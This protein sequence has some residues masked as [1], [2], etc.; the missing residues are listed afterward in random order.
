LDL[1]LYKNDGTGGDQIF[2]KNSTQNKPEHVL[3]DRP[4]TR[5]TTSDLSTSGLAKDDVTAPDD[6]AQ[7]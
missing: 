4:R 1:I 2:E 6:T 5:L 7:K 3:I